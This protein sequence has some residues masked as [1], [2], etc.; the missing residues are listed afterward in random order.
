MRWKGFLREALLF[1]ERL[2]TKRTPASLMNPTLTAAAA[3]GLA[4]SYF[5]GLWL[6]MPSLVILLWRGWRTI[7]RI[8]LDAVLSG[9]FALFLVLLLGGL[10]NTPSFKEAAFYVACAL[11]LPLGALAGAAA[12]GTGSRSRLVASWTLIGAAAGLYA[13]YEWFQSYAGTVF[14]RLNGPL[15]LDSN[16]SAALFNQMGFLFAGYG[17]TR[18]NNRGPIKAF[19]PAALCFGLALWFMSRGA[20]VSL[21]PALSIAAW[22]GF[23]YL[24]SRPGF[25]RRA[26]CV[27]GTAAALLAAAVVAVLPRLTDLSLDKSLSSRWA[28]LEATLEI[29]QGQPFL[30]GAGPGAFKSLYRQH[31]PT[32]DVESAGVHAHNDYAQ[33]LVDGGF[34]GLAAL[35]GVLARVVFLAVAG[36]Q[37]AKTAPRLGRALYLAGA[38]YGLAHAAFN[39]QLLHPV[40]GLLLGVLIG[41]GSTQPRHPRAFPLTVIATASVLAALVAPQAVA[42]FAR[43]AVVEPSWESRIVPEALKE[44]LGLGVGAALPWLADAQLARAYAFDLKALEAQFDGSPANKESYGRQALTHYLKAIELEPNH[45]DYV[46]LAAAFLGRVQAPAVAGLREQLLRQAIELNPA[47]QNAHLA[48]A[49]LLASE[50][51]RAEAIA[52]L[53]EAAKRN[54]LPHRKAQLERG[55]RELRDDG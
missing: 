39:T 16:A 27:L 3:F 31:R 43:K 38:V 42:L 7:W 26:P 45:E 47:N 48:L 15:S 1:L 50:G 25:A 53:E 12:R 36:A 13:A 11:M 29:F 8:R 24:R 23:A 30:T 19:I 52:L 40:P 54:P 37:R 21:M 5:G 6:L 10:A 2:V 20:L 55:L 18:L 34:L 44:P 35:A 49:R 41:L 46:L 28:M 9:L 22:A 14:F 32:E 4:Y 17:A 51:G 33:A